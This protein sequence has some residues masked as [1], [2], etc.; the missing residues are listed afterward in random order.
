MRSQLLRYLP[1]LYILLTAYRVPRSQL[2]RQLPLL[3]IS[4]TA[5][6]VA[7]YLDNLHYC[8]YH[9]L[10][11]EVGSSGR[12][13]CSYSKSVHRFPSALLSIYGMGMGLRLA[14]F[15]RRSSAIIWLLGKFCL[16]D[17]AGSPE[18]ARWFHFARSGSQSQRAIWFILPAGGASHIKE[19]LDRSQYPSA[20]QIREF[21]S[22][23]SL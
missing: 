17:T 22:S 23:Q 19:N 4:L 18:R 3:Y 21:G 12:V 2:V 1:L 13:F 6:R 5:Y 7:S 20:N 16:R 8:I 9:S 14:A 11:T 15:G 10:P